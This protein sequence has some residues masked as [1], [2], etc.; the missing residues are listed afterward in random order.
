VLLPVY[1][2][3]GCR[4]RG[5]SSSSPL[6]VRSITAAIGR[7][8]LVEPWLRGAAEDD[9][10]SRILVAEAPAGVQYVRGVL[11]RILSPVFVISTRSS[12]SSLLA[13]PFNF[14][15]GSGRTWSS[16]FPLGWIVTWSTDF[17]VFFRISL[18]YLAKLLAG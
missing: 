6:D 3:L 2:R 12:S 4:A 11:I 13:T 17:D 14:D 10:A 9:D 15:A 7:F 16:H 8:P 1:W 5:S 18:T